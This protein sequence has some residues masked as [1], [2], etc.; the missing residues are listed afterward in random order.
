M[1][2]K[3]SLYQIKIKIGQHRPFGDKNQSEKCQ[4]NDMKTQ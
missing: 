2:A 4:Y 1:H 3:I